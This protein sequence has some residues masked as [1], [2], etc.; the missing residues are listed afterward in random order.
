MNCRCRTNALVENHQSKPRIQLQVNNK[1]ILRRKKVKIYKFMCER[2]R[3]R[4][5]IDICSQ[6]L[7]FDKSLELLSPINWY[8]CGCVLCCPSATQHTHHRFQRI[9]YLI[10]SRT[11]WMVECGCRWKW[12]IDLSAECTLRLHV[13]NFPPSKIP[14]SQNLFIAF[15]LWH[16][17]CARIHRKCIVEHDTNHQEREKDDGMEVFK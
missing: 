14:N 16:F 7:N 11:A 9:L 3:L 2:F 4:H 13:F 15:C 17:A 1:L 12:L 6:I 10:D 8:I 5:A